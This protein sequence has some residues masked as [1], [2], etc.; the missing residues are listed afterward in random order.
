MA[1]VGVMAWV[2]VARGAVAEAVAVL[3]GWPVTGVVVGEG[4]GGT[5]VF[6]GVAVAVAGAGA[7]LV[8]VA[9]TAVGR[10]VGVLVT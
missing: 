8:A 10:L 9:T 2:A 1:G 6:I 3:V 4:E 5:A 7:L